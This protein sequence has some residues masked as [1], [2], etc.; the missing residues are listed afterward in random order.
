M[1]TL[2]EAGGSGWESS[3]NT[4][5]L[6]FWDIRH[7]HQ[8]RNSRFCWSVSSRESLTRGLQA[9]ATRPGFLHSTREPNASQQ[10]LYRLSHLPR[11]TS[12]S[13][14]ALSSYSMWSSTA[15]I[16]EHVYHGTNASFR[17]PCYSGI[18]QEDYHRHPSEASSSKVFWHQL[19]RSE[20]QPTHA[21]FSFGF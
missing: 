11:P 14:C 5:Y 20:E 16:T 15:L 1:N 12:C 6:T 17:F 4:V 7:I 8:N 3:S 9:Y 2:A 21:S 10:A 18:S 19:M 13:S